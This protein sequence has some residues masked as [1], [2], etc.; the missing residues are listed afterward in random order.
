MI[1]TKVKLENFKLY[2][3]KEFEFGDKEVILLTGSNGFGKTTLIDAIEWCLTGDIAR[4]KKHYKERNPN[5]SEVKRQENKKGIIK[6]S[7]SNIDDIIRVTLTIKVENDEVQIY[8]EQKEDSLYVPTELNFSDNIS[9]DIQKKIKKYAANDKFYNYNICDMSKSYDLINSKRQEIKN[10][11]EDF[12]KPYPLADSVIDKLT[13]LQ[14]HLE[15]QGKKEKIEKDKIEETIYKLKQDI[16]AMRKNIQLVDYPNIQFYQEEIIDIEKESTEKIKEQLEKIKLC[17]YNIIANRITNIIRYYKAKEKI[18][19]IDKLI[20]MIEEK[21]QDLR[22][23]IKNRYYDIQNYEKMKS[24][25]DNISNEKEKIMKASKLIDVDILLNKEI[26]L[27]IIEDIATRKKIIFELEQQLNIMQENIENKKR[28]NE[29]I[30]ALTALVMNREGI[31]K[32][33]NDNH[34]KCPLCG[35]GETFN[36]ISKPAELAVEAELYIERNNAELLLIEEEYKKILDNRNNNFNKL[37]KL[38][39][40]Y[41]DNQIATLIEESKNFELYYEKTKDFFEILQKTDIDINQECIEK[42]KETKNSLEN[43][44]CNQIEI[45]KTLKLIKKIL[46]LTNYSDNL[47]NITLKVLKKV[48]IDCNQ[49]YEKKLIVSNFSFEEFN[50]KILFLTNILNNKELHEKEE[51]LKRYN[52]N[53]VEIESKIEQLNNQGR[54]AKELCD[55]IKKKRADIEKLELKAV[56]PYLYKIFTKVIKHTAITEFKF[57]RDSSRV[58]GGATF[59]DQD[60]NNILN[61]LSQGQIGVFILSYFFANMFIRKD[62]TQ[63]RTYF[64]DDI[65][66][67]MD[68][69]NILSFI[70]I[71]KYQL[72]S[73][74]G[75]INQFFFA[76][77]NNDLERLFIHKMESFGVTIKNFRFTAYG[78]F[79]TVEK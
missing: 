43:I 42:I 79:N 4:I 51:Q 72:Y 28:G 7:K 45:N 25:I 56:G 5:Q 54:K 64:V 10:Q 47:E 8:R 18:V 55:A 74:D 14:D 40:Q 71:I 24:N 6:H 3:Y 61:I 26:Y 1:I 39:V 15:E 59:T 36:K 53:D 9:P 46:I 73:N 13:I 33:K 29:I 77:C 17:G 48:Q 65:T 69:M 22:I 27:S 21:E 50:K 49:L 37:K 12:T 70:E 30:A 35:S 2:K 23:T 62:Q 58:A 76:T 44:L 11:F 16:E 78:E 19:N 31:I 20:K 34:I 32:Y 67:C 38:I 52:N 60:G 75:V 68:D 41:L 57:S 66:S 63:F